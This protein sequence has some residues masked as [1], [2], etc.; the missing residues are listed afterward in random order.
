[1][2]ARQILQDYLEHNQD[3]PRTV[4]SMIRDALA[5]QEEASYMAGRISMKHD[6]REFLGSNAS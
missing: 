3:M 4:V 2:K 1:M 6:M 5:E